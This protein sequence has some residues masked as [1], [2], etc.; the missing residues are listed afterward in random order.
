MSE[1][2]T[3]VAVWSTLPERSPRRADVENVPLVVIRLGGEAHVLHA[4][5][6]HRA[7]D[8]SGGT[9]DG[10][11]L[12]CPEHG[13]DF[14]CDTGRCEALGVDAHRFRC[15]IDVDSDAVMVDATEIRAFHEADDGF[16]YSL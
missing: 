2:P 6:P 4:R 5:C 15:W 8:L 13:W 16:S 10:D 11:L 7:A 9:I 14:R 3:Q 1:L 12:I